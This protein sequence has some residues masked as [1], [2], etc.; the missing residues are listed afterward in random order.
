[1]EEVWKQ[2]EYNN[3]E[4]SNLGNIR[5]KTTKNIRKWSLANGYNKCVLSLGERGKIATVYAHRL[6]AKA[7]LPNPNNLPQ[8]NHKDGNKLNNNVDNLEWVTNKENQIHAR[9]IGLTKSGEQCRNTKLSLE[10]VIFI[11]EHLELTN[12]ELANKFGCDPSNISKIK[13]G[14]IWKKEL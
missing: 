10:Q 5:N 9:D 12:I 8:V 1:M 4:I 2:T 13:N 11:R 7:F 6:V 14:H 3:Y